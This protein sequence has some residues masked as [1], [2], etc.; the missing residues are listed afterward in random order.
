[1]QVFNKIVYDTGSE[2]KDWGM[3]NMNDPNS[4]IILANKFVPY[5]KIAQN[6]VGKSTEYTKK[7]CID[8][9]KYSNS[10]SY[11]SVRLIDGTTVI[12]R[13]YDSLCNTKYGNNKYLQ[14][15]CGSVMVD[16]NGSK[17]P[18]NLGND[19]FKFHV[20]NYGIYPMGTEL[21]TVLT[22][23]K[24]CDKEIGWGNYIGG[25]ENGSGCTAWVLYNENQEYLRCSDLSWNQKHK[26]K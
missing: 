22:F 1:M 2:P 9:N 4:H 23:G 21:E 26:C 3:G 16:I 8:N 6:C 14:N 7:H 19:M 24:Y 10:N 11:A 13:T 18:N 15:V 12:F 17:N 20:T 5:L 25:L